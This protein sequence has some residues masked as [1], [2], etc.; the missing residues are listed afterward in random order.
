M[1]HFKSKCVWIYRVCILQKKNVEFLS[2]FMQCRDHEF[3]SVSQFV[4]IC[5][6]T[7]WIKRFY[8]YELEMALLNGKMESYSYS[9]WSLFPFQGLICVDSIGYLTFELHTRIELS[10][11]CFHHFL[12]LL[13]FEK[14]FYFFIQINT[15][16]IADLRS[17]TDDSVFFTWKS[18]WEQS[19]IW[20]TFSTNL[21][22]QKYYW[23]NVMELNYRMELS[24]YDGF[25][26]NTRKTR[27]NHTHVQ[28]QMIFK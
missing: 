28:E 26:K 19:K 17:S 7:G 14:N 13:L 22:R 20:L 11:C 27:W 2:L 8:T 24:C 3:L 18:K 9:C 5:Y 4:C 21:Y 6:S 16:D 15:S 23:F 10:E 1:F 25:Q 12:F